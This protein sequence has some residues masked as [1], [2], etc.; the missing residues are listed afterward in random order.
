MPDYQTVYDDSA[1]QKSTAEVLPDN[2][3]GLISAQDM[4]DLYATLR[5]RNRVKTFEY[6]STATITV[7]LSVG[8]V[9]TI[10]LK[11]NITSVG[12]VN[13]P[14]VNLIWPSEDLTSGN[15]EK[16]TNTTVA[17][18]NVEDPFGLSTADRL[19]MI[20]GSSTR[21]SQQVPVVAGA[22]YTFGFYAKGAG[23]VVGF[24]FGVASAA[25]TA[26]DLRDVDGSASST[27]GFY[28][29][30]Y[31][32]ATTTTLWFGIDNRA[33]TL[34]TDIYVARI[35]V[36]ATDK[37]DYVKT[38]SGPAGEATQVQV[39]LQ[40]DAT[41]SRLV[42]YGPRV[43]WENSATPTLSTTAGTVDSLVFT[44]TDGVNFRGTFTGKG[45]GG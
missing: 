42:S 45:W 10:I 26:L 15:W 8:T 3:S 7:D 11:N 29:T 24:D 39:F 14:P 21:L 5:D 44:S 4:R 37:T 33:N 23:A 25:G 31:T 12:F 18:S 16:L 30:V 1:F 20:A 22:V 2:A 28:E 32:A 38:T 40:Q 17:G 9:Q 27:W 41:G 6:S 19:T 35:G 34:A 36:F 43:L 13:L